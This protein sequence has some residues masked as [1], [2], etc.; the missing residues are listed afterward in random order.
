MGPELGQDIMPLRPP[1]R[2]WQAGTLTCKLADR[3]GVLHLSV[4]LAVCQWQWPLIVSISGSRHWQL[5][6]V[7]VRV[8]LGGMKFQTQ[9]VPCK[10]KFTQRPPAP[11][12]GNGQPNLNR[13]TSR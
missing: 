4:S 1:H 12:L 6:R 8:Q 10:L 3:V 13:T 11:V 2:H 7:P 5:L 9:A